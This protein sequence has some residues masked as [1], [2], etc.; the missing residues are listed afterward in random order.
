MD[1]N[2]LQQTSN[3]RY[4]WLHT[5]Y[6]LTILWRLLHGQF[7][8]QLDPFNCRP[9]VCLKMMELFHRISVNQVKV[10]YATNSICKLVMEEWKFMINM[11]SRD[12]PV[13]AM[14]TYTAGSLDLCF[15]CKDSPR[16]DIIHTP[17]FK[18]QLYQ[19]C[20][21]TWLKSSNQCV[22]CWKVLNIGNIFTFPTIERTT[23][24]KT[25]VKH[26]MQ[27]DLINANKKTPLRESDRVCPESQEKK[28]QRQLKQGNKMMWTQEKSIKELGAT[29][30]AVVIV[31][32]DHQAVSHT[33]RIVGIIIQVK[34]GDG[35][36]VATEIGILCCR[37][38][39]TAW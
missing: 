21:L 28:R 29:P 9:I 31:K 16:L 22:Y 6:Q 8:D 4:Q 35:A 25:P 11:C 5:C 1:N 36:L 14:E 23:S 3:K 7:D 33:I 32:V 30:G 17:C 19:R 12:L 27:G 15:G 13:M 18:Q 24:I 39:K 38:R 2:W 26:T 34:E 20:I 10:A 37:T